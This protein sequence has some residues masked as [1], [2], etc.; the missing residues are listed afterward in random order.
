[1]IRGLRAR[2]ALTLLVVLAT[3]T[4]LLACSNLLGFDTLTL[5]PESSG[6]AEG[7]PETG[8]D[9]PIT[10]GDGDV[11]SGG[12]SCTGADLATS[13]QHCGR[14]NHGCGGSTCKNSQ[15]QPLQLAD[16]LA[17]PEGL[18]VDDA[19]VFVAEYDSDRI[20]RLDKTPHGD[21]AGSPLPTSCVFAQVNAVLP[22]A[23]GIDATNVYWTSERRSIRSCPRAGC[24]GQA[25]V[26]RVSFGDPV[27]QH[28]QGERLPLDLVVRDGQIFF[29]ESYSGA[30]KSVAI[31]TGVVTTYLPAA[32]G[33]F[34]PVALAVD[35]TNVYFTGDGNS[36]HAAEILSVPRDGSGAF[37]L[38]ADAAGRTWGIGLAPSGTLFWTVP[39]FADDS[40]G[41]VQA[42]AKTADGGAPVGDFASAQT[43]PRG[44]V[45]DAANVYWIT[46]GTESQAT[47]MVLYC[48]VAGCPAAGPIVLA[49][50]Q[51]APRHI[52]QDDTALYWSNEGLAGG[53]NHDG[54]VWKIAKP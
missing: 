38:L 43:D 12:T 47:G 36:S 53:S 21:C 22:T 46:A 30:V 42:T 40:D 49:A 32:A 24:G 31:D 10:T 4:T 51:R 2:S 18:V 34:A 16:G 39:G 14:C 35:D 41:R 9:G 29:P 45:V 23:M 26:T 27:F 11:D 20:L 48:P 17:I 13:A 19:S 15:C 28:L 25:P 54:Q 6:Q 3:T 50:Q 1:L 7:G 37:K 44:L 33:A 5:D 8:G 52:T